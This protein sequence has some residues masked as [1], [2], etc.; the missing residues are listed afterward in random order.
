MIRAKTKALAGLLAL[1]MC[2][3][4]AAFAADTVVSTDW[5]EANLSKVTVVDV[6]KVEDYKAGHVPAAINA[7][8][9]AWVRPKEGLQNELPPDDDLRAILSALSIEPDTRVVVM[10]SGDILGSANVTRVAWTLKYAGVGTVSI[11]NGGF[12][13]WAAGGKPVSKDAVK[14]KKKPYMGRLSK[15][16]SYLVSKEELLASIGKAVIVDAREPDFYSG[17]KKAG[18]I[19]RPGHI[20]GAVNLPTSRAFNADGTFKALPELEAIARRAVGSDKTR[21]II[22]Y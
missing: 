20:K 4:A 15:T 21:E 8:F 22:L 18:I 5:L 9:G 2:V 3:P 10:G 14:L 17:A 11:L 19:D 6:R 12:E 1:L 16:A 7:Y 13:K